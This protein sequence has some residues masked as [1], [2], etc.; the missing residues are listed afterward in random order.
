MKLKQIGVLYQRY[1]AAH[2][3]EGPADHRGLVEFAKGL[4]DPNFLAPAHSIGV[5]PHEFTVYFGCN[6]DASFPA[7]KEN[8]VLAFSNE[9]SPGGR[10]VL[11]ADG[12][13]WRMTEKAFLT[14]PRPKV[15]GK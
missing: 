8:T 12:K 3:N 13:A 11:T 7:G 5:N 9:A 1:W 2:K 10:F 15:G 4:D 14:A 6:R